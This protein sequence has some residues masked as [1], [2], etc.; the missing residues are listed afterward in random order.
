MFND[1]FS[2][3]KYSPGRCKINDNIGLY[4]I[5]RLSQI[6]TDRHMQRA[7][8]S[9]ITQ[10]FPDMCNADTACQF[11]IFIFIHGFYYLATHAAICTVYEY[12]QHTITLPNAVP[13]RI[14]V[15]PYPANI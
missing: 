5:N 10:V 4:V 3:I 1:R 9:N 12:L 11:Q 7:D 6:V 14:Y 13:V 15:S 2:I 8:T